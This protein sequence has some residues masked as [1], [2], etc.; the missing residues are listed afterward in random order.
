MSQPTILNNHAFDFACEVIT[1]ADADAVTADELRHALL[2]RASEVDDAEL[3]EACDCFDSHEMDDK[4]L[5]MRKVGKMTIVEEL[6]GPE[7][8]AH[9]F[10]R[11]PGADF[12]IC[13]VTLQNGF[14]LTGQAGRVHRGNT[15]Y[16]TLKVE[17]ARDA[18]NKG[19]AFAAYRECE[20]LW[21]Q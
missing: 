16:E 11:I 4:E 5:A 15:S 1:K 2:A 8:K 18:F 7:Y 14:V 9:L 20:R 6:F 13:A 10:V 19:A 12:V 17:A 3:L 21:P